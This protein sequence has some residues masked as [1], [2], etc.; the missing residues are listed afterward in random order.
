MCPKGA[1]YFFGC[2]HNHNLAQSL[3][4]LSRLVKLFYYCLNIVNKK[5]YK[6]CNTF[7]F[8]GT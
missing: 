1:E 6:R 3:K 4:P 5:T 2:N 7:Y 8:I